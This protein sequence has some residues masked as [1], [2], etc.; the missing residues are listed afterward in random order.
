MRSPLHTV[1][2][3]AGLQGLFKYCVELNGIDRF[4]EM[5][6]ESGRLTAAVIFG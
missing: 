1:T 3:S 4:Y 6:S 5:M 2:F